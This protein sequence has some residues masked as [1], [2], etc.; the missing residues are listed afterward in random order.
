LDL[1]PLR[2]RIIR[3]LGVKPVIDPEAEIAR[4]V[5]FLKRYLVHSGAKGYVLGISGGQDSA[6]AGRLTQLAVEAVRKERPDSGVYFVALRLPYGVQRDEEDAQVAMRFIR[7]DKEYTVNIKAAVD[8]SAAAYYEATG[9][10]LRDYVKGNTKARERMKVQY[11]FAGQR[12][13]LVVGTDHA[14]EA[15][16]GFFTKGGDGT[17]DVVPLAGLTKRQGKALLKA[18][19]APERI[20]LK[21]PTADLLDERPGQPD[22]TELGITYDQIDD[23]L[24]GKPVDPGVAEKIERRFLATQHKRALP[25]TP[26]DDWWRS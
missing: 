26:N 22:E 3:E 19:N 16:T 9:E 8:A 13:L 7:A 5:E 21:V 11:D 18:L 10:P 6:L 24:E 2:E 17:C 4:R 23:Y 14:A 20:Y 15:V 25:V 12:G 1:T